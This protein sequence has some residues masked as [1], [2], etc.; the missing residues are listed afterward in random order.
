MERSSKDRWRRPTAT[1]WR[2]SASSS[3]CSD[4]SKSQRRFCDPIET[5]LT[6][7]GV[8]AEYREEKVDPNSLNRTGS[9]TWPRIVAHNEKTSI[10]GLPDPRH[11]YSSF[12][13]VLSM[14]L[15]SLSRRLRSLR[16]QIVA[17]I[18]VSQ[19]GLFAGSAN[20]QLGEPFNP[21]LPGT[22]QPANPFETQTPGKSP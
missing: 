2:A 21:G 15:D 19:F 4:Y 8:F 17:G 1:F 5:I 11:W 9:A 16:F 10:T 14:S 6:G 7:E 22:P 20:A 18:A 12:R 3:C 13:Q